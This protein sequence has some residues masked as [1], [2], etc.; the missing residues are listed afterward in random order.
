MRDIDAILRLHGKKCVDYG[1]SEPEP[2][3]FIDVTYN[4]HEESEAANLLIPTLNPIQRQI[5]DEICTFIDNDR[6]ESKFFLTIQEALVR[7]ISTTQS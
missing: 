7:L 2:I 3:P 5:F 1:L 6:V 4:P